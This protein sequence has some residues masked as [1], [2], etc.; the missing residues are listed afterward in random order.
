MKLADAGFWALATGRW[1]DNLFLTSAQ[2][3]AP[4]LVL[5]LLLSACI[6]HPPQRP[7]PSP[8]PPPDVLSIPEPVPKTEPRSTLGNPTFYEVL[9]K[10]YF[11]LPSSEG[12]IERGVASWYGPGFHK[13]RT[14]TGDAYDMYAMTAAHKTLPL[15]CY[16]RVTN[17]R[18]GHSVVVR[19]NDRGPFKDGRIID[20]SFTAASKLDMIR[21]GTALVEV[22]VVGSDGGPAPAPQ[23]SAKVAPLY[24]QAGAFSDEANATRLATRLK[25]AGLTSAFVRKDMS[26][27]REIHRVRIGPI[28]T[29]E[30]FDRV[31]QQLRTL[32]VDDARLAAS[33]DRP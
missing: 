9:G 21:E 25:S 10:R 15:P 19:I 3:P 22:Q 2:R 4:F 13:E 29:V 27:T 17:L 7:T 32:G 6:S 24:V 23:S 30:E 8:P 1:R 28:A 14:A 18:N 11:V 26:G 31:V 20:L 16:A 33:D 12:Y 5:A